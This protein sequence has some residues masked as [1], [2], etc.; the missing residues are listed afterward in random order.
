MTIA[1]PAVPPADVAA[2]PHVIAAWA[3]LAAWLATPGGKACAAAGADSMAVSGS[4]LLAC[5]QLIAACKAAAREARRARREAGPFTAR[6]VTAALRGLFPHA[7]M[8]SRALGGGQ[9]RVRLPVASANQLGVTVPGAARA[10]AWLSGQL[11]VPVQVTGTRTYQRRDWGPFAEFTVIARSEPDAQT[12]E[13]RRGAGPGGPAA[14]RRAR[15]PASRD[16]GPPEAGT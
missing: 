8:S 3:A 15:P 4:D 5:D 2:D 12:G 13:G 9:V 1:F 11:G 7:D 16:P 14:R 10:S 6:V